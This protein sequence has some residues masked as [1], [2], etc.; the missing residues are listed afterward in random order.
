MNKINIY[1]QDIKSLRLRHGITQQKLADSL[2][3]INVKN[4]AS[5]ESGRR[6]CQPIVLW[7]MVLTWDK[8]DLWEIGINEWRKTYAPQDN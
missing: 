8:E 3:G 7:A 6:G 4:V 5:W 2:F 1:P